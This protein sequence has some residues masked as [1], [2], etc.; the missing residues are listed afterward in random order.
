MKKGATIGGALEVA[1]RGARALKGKSLPSVQGGRAG[2]RS[3][4]G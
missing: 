4:G 2:F 1:R 3:A